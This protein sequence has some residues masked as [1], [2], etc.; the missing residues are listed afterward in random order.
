[1]KPEYRRQSWRI[2]NMQK[3]LK[4]RIIRDLKTNLFRYLAL[5]FLI[6][7]GMYILVSLIGAAETIMQGSDAN[8]IEQHLEDGE[9]STFIPLTKDELTEITKQGITLEEMFYLDFVMKQDQS[10]LRIFKNR[11]Q[12][13]CLALDEGGRIAMEKNEIVL[14]KRYGEEHDLSIGDSIVVGT[15]TYVIVGFGSTPDYDAP[16]K[17]LSDT[18][19]DSASFGTA[20]VTADAYEELLASGES[21]KSQEY[22]YSYLLNGKLTDKEFKELLKDLDFDADEVADPYFRDYWEETGGKQ[23]ELTEGVDKLYDGA[24]ELADGL[25]ELI[26]HNGELNG[27]ATELFDAYLEQAYD[28]LKAYGLKEQLTEENFESELTDLKNK[29]SGLVGLSI[30]NLL[31]ELKSIKEFKDGIGE[32]TDGAAEAAEGAEEIADGVKELK[33]ATDELTDQYFNS[34]FSILTMF[35]AREDNMRIGGAADDQ[36]INKQAGLVIGVIIIILFTYVI[37]VFVV[38]NI[39]R[40]SSVIGALYAMGV[41]RKE[42]LKHYLMLPVMITGISGIV[43]VILAFTPIGIY[44]QMRDSYA[45]FSTPEFRIICPVYLLVYGIVMPPVV[46]AVVNYLVIRKQLSRTALSLLRNEEKRQKESKLALGQLGFIGRFRIRQMLK[47][48]RTGL[49]VIF[50]LFISL[51]CMM[52]S[53]NCLA[54]VDHISK[55]SKTDTK[56]EYMYTYKYP[57]ETVPEGGEAAYAVTL[58]K[59]I[60]GFN[61]EVTLMGIDA[62]NP[63][64]DAQTV[65]GLN[66]VV[67]GSATAQRFGLQVGD[68]FILTDAEE[69][70]DYAFTVAGIARYAAGLYAFMDIDSMRKLFGVSDDYYNL[71][72]ADQELQIENGRLYAKTSRQEI[73]QS[74]DVF[75]DLMSGFIVT[76]LIVSSLI[77][78]VVMYLMMKVM[79]DRSAYSISMMKIFGYRMGEIRKLYLN[80]NFYIVAVGALVCIP[81]TKKLMDLLYPSVM[82]PNVACG[83]DLSFH[84]YMY[85]ILYAGIIFFYFIVNRMLVGRLKRMVPA[86]VL[87]NRE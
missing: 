74:A 61:M 29:N 23:D 82:V 14:E 45:Y 75:V 42:L 48:T 28:G 50:G 33:E 13:N 10:T 12:I 26:G 52:I 32:Y 67:I 9:F 78:C 86:D 58:N 70:R 80:G 71:V 38:H 30:G 44:T 77:I 47:E 7:L 8:Q 1:M 5:G 85:V 39:E 20:F 4:K 37:S 87:K 51:L 84:W 66:Q 27:A 35:M 55:D 65:E 72:F 49:T 2:Y 53:L 11:E 76:I 17:N 83:L 40:E 41:K 31:S 24:M 79:V 22:L 43:G 19:V 60:Y 73:T 18:S 15:K 68:Q 46:A 57:T 21:V 69:D 34:G 3:I 36:I 25:T 6:V 63:Y 59:K 54:L 62:D 81:V 16:Y 64:F 56:F